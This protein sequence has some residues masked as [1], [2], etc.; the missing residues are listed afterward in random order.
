MFSQAELQ[1][2][3]SRIED[4]QE[5]IKVL[6]QQIK[7]AT[8]D[9]EEYQQFKKKLQNAKDQI[10]KE[11]ETMNKQKS[12]LESQIENLKNNTEKNEDSNRKTHQLNTKLDSLEEVLAGH[13]EKMENAQTLEDSLQIKQTQLNKK[14]KEIDHDIEQAEMLNKIY[15]NLSQ[16]IR[17]IAP[18]KLKIID[19]E[20]QIQVIQD[21]QILNENLIQTHHEEIKILQEKQRE[22]ISE[23]N[24][25]ESKLN[26]I[27]DDIKN[28]ETE[29]V[30]LYQDLDKLNLSFNELNVQRKSLDIQYNTLIDKNKLEDSK[31]L[32]Q[33]Q[34]LRQRLAI[35]HQE[36]MSMPHISQ[37][38]IEE[39]S[40]EIMKKKQIETELQKRYESVLSEIT[41]KYN[42][43]PKVMNLTASLGTQWE[44]YARLTNRSN[45]LEKK[46]YKAQELA[47]RKKFILNEI[48]RQVVKKQSKPG[49]DY[50]CNFYDEM[51]KENHILGLKKMA[52][53]AEEVLYQ[54]DHESLIIKLDELANS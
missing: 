27:N 22:R 17:K 46:L 26:S 13:I 35:V 10:E 12:E 32:E 43:S 34:L 47:Q 40:L 21:Q 5:K 20:S 51:V 16:K 4:F 9:Y 15:T 6:E 14:E 30:K 31:L 54:S 45:E 42:K 11:K 28:A 8:V 48:R 50:L 2:I 18:I 3:Q 37:Q 36:V 38:E 24:R 25:S 29:R 44:E 49:Y 41:Q 52:A 53:S 23:L 7:I 39:Q 1:V 33:N 19:L